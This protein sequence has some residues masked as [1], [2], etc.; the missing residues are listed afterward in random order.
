MT[1]VMGPHGSFVPRGH[2]TKSP[3]SNLDLVSI[4][5]VLIGCVSLELENGTSTVA[6]VDLGDAVFMR[7]CE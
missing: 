1:V 5:K 6:T 2:V 7:K 3:G 4:R